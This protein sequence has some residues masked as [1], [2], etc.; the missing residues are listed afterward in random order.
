MLQKFA[1]SSQDDSLSLR[2]KGDLLAQKAAELAGYWGEDP[3]EMPIQKV[4]GILAQFTVNLKQSVTR[5]LRLNHNAKKAAKR[6]RESC[7]GIVYQQWRQKQSAGLRRGPILDCREPWRSSELFGVGGSYG[8]T[9]ELQ[10]AKACRHDERSAGQGGARPWGQFAVG[11]FSVATYHRSSSSAA[12]PK[13]KKQQEEIYILV[14]R[15]IIVINVVNVINDIISYSSGLL[16]LF[17]IK[18]KNENSFHDDLELFHRIVTSNE[19]PRKTKGR[20]RWNC[21]RVR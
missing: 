6:W 4:A 15:F 16:L 7:E 2:K 10:A 21:T 5:L 8:K 14:S 18:K 13:H 17:K 12:N 3:R 9:E 1:G 19:C 20:N 11:I